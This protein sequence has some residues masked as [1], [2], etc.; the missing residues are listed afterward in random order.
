MVLLLD[1]GFILALRNEN[2]ENHKYA[3]ELTKDKILKGLYGKIIVTDYIFDELMTL[4]SVRIKKK[5]FM[6]KTSDFLTKSKK[7]L[8]VKIS[9]ELVWNTCEKFYQYFDQGLSFTDCTFL[10]IAD[11]FKNKCYTATFDKKLAS[12]TTNIV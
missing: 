6:K 1:T 2:D 9:E 5:D 11:N 8:F 3:K 7:V 10:S 12:F 4:I